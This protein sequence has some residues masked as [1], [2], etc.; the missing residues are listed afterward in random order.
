MLRKA[1]LECFNAISFY[2]TDSENTDMS[3]QTFLRLG[4]IV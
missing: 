2:E 1:I 4:L 3:L